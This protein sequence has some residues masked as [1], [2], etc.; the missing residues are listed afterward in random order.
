MEKNKPSNPL[1]TPCK[2]SSIPRLSRSSESNPGVSTSWL[3]AIYT[4][5][6]LLIEQ[7][8]VDLSY[9]WHS[10]MKYLPTWVGRTTQNF[11][12][13][14]PPSFLASRSQ[15]RRSTLARACTLRKKRDC[16][17]SRRIYERS[18]WCNVKRRLQR[19]VLD[20]KPCRL[21]VSNNTCQKSETLLK[22]V[23]K[24]MRSYLSGRR[25]NIT[26]IFMSSSSYLVHAISCRRILL[27]YRF[28][29][30]F[31]YRFSVFG[32]PFLFL[33]LFFKA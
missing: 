14:L 16:S 6:L 27:K 2:S 10:A 4:T 30:N 23:E 12:L 33:F 17:Q 18:R 11:L 7:G 13:R 5:H 32:F 19:H 21:R 28:F 20:R 29:C 26:L 3:N 1:W 25:I 31:Y 15:L 8:I 24:R 9:I 22:H